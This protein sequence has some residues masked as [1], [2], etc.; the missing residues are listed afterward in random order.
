MFFK[1]K[2]YRKIELYYKNINYQYK[3]IINEENML[4]LKR[5][6]FGN[7]VL[8]LKKNENLSFQD[9]IL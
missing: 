2:Y 4:H 8:K 3:E 7:K 9:R 1:V 5:L 6:L